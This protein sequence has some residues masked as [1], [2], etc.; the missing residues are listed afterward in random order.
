MTTRRT[1]HAAALLALAILLVVMGAA[2]RPV[3]VPEP[4]AAPP[5]VL[6]D[7]ESGFVRDMYAH[8]QQALL[9]VAA[10]DAQASPTVLRLARQIE[11]TQ[12]LEIGLMLGWLQMAGLITTNPDPMAWMPTERTDH[13]TLPAMPGYISRSDIDRLAA[14]RGREAEILFLHVMRTHHYGAVLM[15]RGLDALVASGPVKRLA[16][17]ITTTQSQEIG[18]ITTLLHALQ[19]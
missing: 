16:R 14:A 3:L 15:A 10:L 2:V 6:N 5:L 9:L 7:T 19:P 11:G 13:H 1:V 4:A 12:N 18:F 17:D 8:H